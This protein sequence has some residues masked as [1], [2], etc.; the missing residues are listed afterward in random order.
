M[1]I[2]AD[3]SGIMWSGRTGLLLNRNVPPAQPHQVFTKQPHLLGF[4]HKSTIGKRPLSVP[5]RQPADA[6][7]RGSSLFHMGSWSSSLP[8][9]R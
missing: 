9:I 3:L 5:F 4:Y 6:E 1:A 8:A 7:K 2:D